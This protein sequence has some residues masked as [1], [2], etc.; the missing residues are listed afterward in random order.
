VTAGPAIAV[1]AASALGSAVL[2]RAVRDF[3][4]RRA[5]L[6]RPNDRSSH[7]I[8]KPRLGG[9][10]VMA[11]PLLLGA[12]LVVA[13]HAPAALLL[14]LL[15]TGLV[16]LLG[17]ADDLRPVRA[18]VRFGVQVALASA[19]VAASYGRLPAAAGL[20]GSSIPAPALAVLAVLWITWLTNL[21]NFMDGIDGLAG[22]QA[23]LAS[24]GLLVV[25]STVGAGT[26][27]WLLLAVLGSSLG[28]LLFNFP[29][30]TIFMGDVGSTALGFFFGCLPLLPGA[31]P[32]PVEP[33]AIALSLFVLDATTTLVR[34]IARGETWHAPHRTHL[35][36]RPVVAGIGHRAV[37][38]TAGAG[39]A[40]AAACAA[41]WPA[42][43][44]SGKVAAVAVP[45]VLFAAGT[46][47]VRRLER[48]HR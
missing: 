27:A 35:Y 2:V 40:V 32:V 4:N 13:G 45:L 17:L 25:A 1:A 7:S 15:A 6:D 48:V 3:A 44:P 26:S 9:V 39:M 46:L 36:Q 37:T 22:G 18:R 14:P 38:L 8:P 29:P 30:A 31:P 23:F 28:F 5:L 21:Y 33:V 47:A 11:P 34:R 16:A 19:V 24:A 41:A 12:G 42:A 10:G 43:G 20:L